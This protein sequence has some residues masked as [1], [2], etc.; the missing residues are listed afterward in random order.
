MIER[1]EVLP[2]PHDR[3]P[4]RCR[5]NLTAGQEDVKSLLSLFPQKAGKPWVP[6]M[7]PFRLSLYLYG[8]TGDERQTLETFLS[9]RA[10]PAAQGAS[11]PPSGAAVAPPKEASGPPAPTET[12]FAVPEEGA[13]EVE[14]L[15]GSPDAAGPPSVAPVPSEEAPPSL[16]Q[17]ATDA[18][19]DWAQSSDNAPPP[20]ARPLPPSARTTEGSAVP[21][22]APRPAEPSVPAFSA[23]EI[24][25]PAEGLVL[26]REPE[27]DV[28]KGHMF[29]RIGYFVPEDMGG[30]G[31]TIHGLFTQTLQSRRM[32]FVFHRVFA[33]SYRW[34]DKALVEQ[35]VGACRTHRVDALI[36]V[37]DEKRLALVIEKCEEAGIRFY[38][39]KREDALKRYWRLGLITRIV[40]HEE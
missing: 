36:G 38:P 20:A 4:D 23:S 18:L 37:G 3:F 40:I 15:S 14:V 28:P 6:R 11:S 16:I 12:V 10:R 26:S 30:V 2:D 19:M 5:L 24:G 22:P 13:P 17:N 29:F 21:P 9:G 31:E 1:W 32:P 33:F 25:M 7:G 35:L 39:L 8:L 34:P 27:P